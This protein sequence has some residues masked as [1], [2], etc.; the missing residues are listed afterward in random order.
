MKV[1]N[2]AVG[3]VAITLGLA[4]VPQIQTGRL[5]EYCPPAGKVT[6]LTGYPGLET[7]PSF[8]PDGTQIAFV[9]G[10]EKDDNRDIYVIRLGDT[11]PVRLTNDPGID[12]GPVWSPDGSQIAFG[13]ST[14]QG[15]I[16][17]YLIPSDGGGERKL[18]DMRER[19]VWTGSSWS[20]DGRW[21]AVGGLVLENPT[22]SS[23][24]IHLIPLQPG[25]R[26]PLFSKA[27]PSYSASPAFSP[28]GRFL[29]FVT[30]TSAGAE[31][32][33]I[34][35]L[36]RNYSPKG[37][38]RQLTHSGGS[39]RGVTWT[40][41]GQTLLYS[42]SADNG[43]WL[44]RLHAFNGG[45]AERLDF[46]G[47]DTAW[48]TVA[49]KGNRLVYRSGEHDYDIWRID[50]GE[51]P[52]ESLFRERWAIHPRFSYDGRRLTFSS[53]REGGARAIWISNADGTKARRL[54]IALDGTE[55]YPC[56]SPDGRSIAFNASGPS[57]DRDVFVVDITGTN[58]RQVSNDPADDQQPNWSP[59]GQW[60]YFQS[61][62]SGRWEVMRVP[63]SGGEAVQ[64]TNDGGYRPILSPDG[65]ML[66]YLK[67]RIGATVPLC[68]R[69][70]EG[71][72]ERQVLESVQWCYWV[73]E[74]GIYYF[75]PSGDA[76]SLALQYHDIASGRSRLLTIVK[77]RGV[78]DLT[79][80][81]D[82]KTVLFP[83]ES[84]KRIDL[85]LAEDF[86]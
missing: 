49:P 13:R 6:L 5:R 14:K 10:G 23:S 50:V 45:E 53:R 78:E 84:P 59:D 47:P 37:A 48:P 7:E 35:E 43:A 61:N 39:I 30:G 81:P 55:D 72:P 33:H 32:I 11:V 54:P 77:N 34:I 1:A 29:A 19:E 73:V 41:D 17:I 75:A 40:P 71:G 36:N 64:V 80:S 2:L 79:V 76:G 16:A 60:I 22:R 83:A 25:K 67:P 3:L 65:R 68:V 70:T 74:G 4:V 26:R 51:M 85:M 31:D 56:W 9:W 18:T 21:L 24:G 57:G 86:K 66:Y 28:D 27:A 38:P 52:K 15:Q 63:P 42:R 46:A 44:W 58:L 62:R 20:P 8:S 69:P 82:G 12:R